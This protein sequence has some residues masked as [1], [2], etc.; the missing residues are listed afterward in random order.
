[1]CGLRPL[2]RQPGGRCYGELS[3]TTRRPLLNSAP[4]TRVAMAGRSFCVRPESMRWLHRSIGLAQPRPSPPEPLERR[5]P[6]AAPFALAR[7]SA[8]FECLFDERSPRRHHFTRHRRRRRP[9]PH[10][11]TE[12][13]WASAR[14]MARCGRPPEGFLVAAERAASCRHGSVSVPVRV[15][16]PATPQP[17]SRAA[18]PCPWKQSVPTALG[19]RAI[20]ALL[21]FR[22]GETAER[23]QR[24]GSPRERGRRR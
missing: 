9:A 2:R 6:S 23:A 5:V 12:V 18:N 8:A 20:G 13:C 16:E 11:H 15:R 19:M 4:W 24:R 21:S 22:C 3:P 7:Q 14:G 10:P 1:M 17:V